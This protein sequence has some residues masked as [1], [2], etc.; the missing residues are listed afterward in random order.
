MALASIKQ[1]FESE[2]LAAFQHM[3]VILF[4]KQYTDF[5]VLLF[6]FTSPLSLPAKSEFGIEVAYHLSGKK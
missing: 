2:E 5:F 4:S 3:E 1:K 6:Y